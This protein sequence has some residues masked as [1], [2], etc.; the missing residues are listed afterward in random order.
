MKR[1]IAV[2]IPLIVLGALIGWRLKLKKQEAETETQMMVMRMKSPPVVAVAPA[3]SRDIVHNFESVGTV[4]APFNV[5][6]S[7]KITGRIIHLGVR[8]GDR[9]RH[10]Q[11]LV[12]IDPSEVEAEVRQQQAVVAEARYRLAQAQ[13]SQAPTNAAITT[14]IRQQQASLAS[15]QADYN[16][17]RENYESQ[18]GT[19]AATV[20][21]VQGRVDNANATIE[22]AE[23][24]IR[25]A[26]A[27][28]EN[29]RVRYNRVN[30]L[31]K[32]GFIAEQDV[33]DARTSM[34]VQ[35]GALDVAVSQRKAATA[36]RDSAAAQKQAAEKQAAIVKAK[37]KADIEAAHAKVNQA[38]AALDYA[39][40]NS[41]QKPAYQQSL[42]ALRAGV[43]AAQSVLRNAEARR[44]DTIL[45]SS[46][47]GFVTARHM[48]P[49]AVATPGQP[50]VTVEALRQ[51]WATVPVPEEVSRMIHVGQVAQA[52]FDAMPGRTFSGKV[53]QIN[54]SA[55]PASRQFAMRVLLDN[56]QYLLKPGMY[57]RVSLVTERVEMATIVPREAVQQS[58]T[59]PTVAV[60]DGA[61]SIRLHPVTLGAE[62]A[63]G[64]SITRGVKPG[65]M[66]VIMSAM[67]LKE[68]QVVRVAGGKEG[69]GVGARRPTATR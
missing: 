64:I 4:E 58:K 7:S 31:F 46:I 28:L 12:R 18:L 60:V 40:A 22:N 68:G 34:S 13:I 24:A 51:V 19:A 27:N 63:D 25:S 8:E 1:A 52:T 23:A 5:N 59:G 3:Q 11:V 16:Q 48:D 39:K 6:I 15:A 38:E 35:Q 14:Q 57:A 43:A 20:A 50:I 2:L 41:A 55:D 29:A 45:R 47:D 61:N 54:P 42:G 66:V 26:K 62:D 37:G 36:Q 56:S 53:V 67:R 44:A 65:D 30:G 17:A 21:D 32:Q 69:K 49:G 33:D 9:V 10:G